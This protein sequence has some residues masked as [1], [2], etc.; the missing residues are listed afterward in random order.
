[1]PSVPAA[2]Q[3]CSNHL[4]L[5]PMSDSFTSSNRSVPVSIFRLSKVVHFDAY[6]RQGS[7]KAYLKCNRCGTF[8]PLKSDGTSPKM[9]EHWGGESAR[10]LWRSWRGRKQISSRS[11]GRRLH[12]TRPLETP[13]AVCLSSLLI[14]VI[15]DILQYHN[16]K[17]TPAY[18][19]LPDLHPAMFPTRARVP[20]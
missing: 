5:L 18:G 3:E 6:T 8:P 1:M 15:S 2:Y 13:L 9:I 10:R 11:R 19:D 20:P 17:T 16:D 12:M 14:S 4:A 7:D